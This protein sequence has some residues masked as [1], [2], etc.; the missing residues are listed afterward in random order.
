MNIDQLFVVMNGC[1][2]IGWL[3]IIFVSPFWKRYDL[4]VIGIVSVLLAI[5]YTIFNI[6]SF[7][8][9]IF[10]K[11]ATLNG[12]MDLFVTKP[13]V[14]AAWSHILA[15]DLIG[16]VWM[17]KNSVKHGISHWVML[18]SFIFTFLLGPFGFLIYKITRW[19]KTGKY[20][21]DN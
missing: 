15:F 1:A 2:G 17:K 6:T 9:D 21:A 8:P 13:F 16:G 18:P 11:F 5:A 7:R 20:F 4:V 19:V 3:L 14:M 10:Q 12:I